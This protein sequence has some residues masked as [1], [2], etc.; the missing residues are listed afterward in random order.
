MKNS[1][2]LLSIA[3]SITVLAIVSFTS[4]YSFA[5]DQ[6]VPTKKELATLLKTAKEPADHLRVA[7]YYKQEAARQR[8]IAKEHADLAVIYQERHPFAAM[9]AKH[10][11]TSGQSASHCK[12]FAELALEQAKEDDALVVLH[13]NMAKEAPQKQQ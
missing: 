4:L 12:K 8:Q 6:K 9:Q 7:A 1:R 11:D 10:G 2:N 3:L 13:E 5:Q